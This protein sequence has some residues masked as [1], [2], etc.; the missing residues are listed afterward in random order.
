MTAW[1]LLVSALM[2]LGQADR[3]APPP[4]TEKQRARIAELVRSTQKEAAALNA[5]LDRLQQALA[6]KYEEFD[7]DVAAVEKLQKEIL[8][9]QRRLLDNYH[10]LQVELRSVVGT[11]R[12]SVLSMCI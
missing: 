4:L 6:K 5:R 3:S 12:F 7:L 2:G 8:D 1:P 11:E 9:A 10:R